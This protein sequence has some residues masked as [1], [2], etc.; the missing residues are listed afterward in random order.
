[1]KE[2]TLNINYQIAELSELNETEQTLVKKAMEA[3]NNSY[4][5]YSHFYVGAACLLARSE[6]SSLVPIRRMPHSLLVFAQSEVPS[7]AHS[8]TIRNRPSSPWP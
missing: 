1:M 6:E 3:T 7:S 4:A 2:Q 5:N 8:L